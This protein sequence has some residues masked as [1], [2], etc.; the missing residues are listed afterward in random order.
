[1]WTREK[2]QAFVDKR[3]GVMISFLI[4]F[5][6]IDRFPSLFFE[7]KAPFGAR[8]TVWTEINRPVPAA[9]IAPKRCSLSLL[10][11]DQKQHVECG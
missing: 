6:T 1:M 5:L 3:A 11:P 8:W 7:R 9:V 4:Y 2:K 10:P